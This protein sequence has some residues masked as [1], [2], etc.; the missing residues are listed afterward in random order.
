MKPYCVARSSSFSM[1]P[2]ILY[3]KFNYSEKRLGPEGPVVSKLATLRPEVGMF[4]WPSYRISQYD[5]PENCRFFVLMPNS[6]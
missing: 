6:L 5:T 1:S 3:L 4:G 2:T